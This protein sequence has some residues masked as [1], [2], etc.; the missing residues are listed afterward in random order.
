MTSPGNQPD[1][2]SVSRKKKRLPVAFKKRGVRLKQHSLASMLPNITTV[3]ALSSG[4][5]S[6]R[7]AMMERWELAILAIFLAGFLDAMDGRLARYLG[8][9]SRFGAE[10]DSF[11]DFISFGAS[12]ALIVYLRSLH[13]WGGVGWGIILF[14]TVCMA[15]RLARFNVVSI[16]GNAPA[17]SQSYFTG[18]P[19]PAAAMLALTP[20]IMD[21]HWGGK[22]S[23]FLHP[24]FSAVILLS[25][26]LLMVSRVPTFSLKKVSVPHKFVLPLMLVAAILVV[27]LYSEPWLTLSLL[28]VIYVLTI[29]FSILSCRRLEKEAKNVI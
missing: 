9:S 5:T 4:L 29:P 28:A 18:V 3:L 25:V 7:F 23:I 16:E 26:S 14:F 21:L 8:S 13:L 24:M 6:V 15:L 17:W 12:P 10:L 20:L 11:S 2:V 27:A 22:T 1:L 19:A